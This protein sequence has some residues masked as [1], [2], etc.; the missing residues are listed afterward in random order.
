MVFRSEPARVVAFLAIAA[1]ATGLIGCGGPGVG[2]DKPVP[3][4]GRVFVGDEPLGF[5]TVT[6]QPSRGGQPA[7]GV[8]GSDGSFELTTSKP[9][10]GAVPGKHA[11]R[12]A[13]FESQ[14]PAYDGPK[15]DSLGAS[16][17]AKKYTSHATS[18]L[19]ALIVDGGNQPV[20]L[21]LDPL[22]EEQPAEE[23]PTEGEPVAAGD[24]AAEVDAAE[25]D[26][27]EAEA[28]AETPEEVAEAEELP[29]EEQE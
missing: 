13:C 6:F 1:T 5:G 10:D 14:D 4:T 8:I 22:P 29:A 27:A 15:G 26:A 11:I 16:L 3:V 12:V 2:Q 23:E 25:A 9:G 7:R 20:I 19:T 18:G 17:I 28:A 24:E 21:K